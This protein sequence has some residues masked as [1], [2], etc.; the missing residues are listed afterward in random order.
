[1]PARPTQQTELSLSGGRGLG[2]P[3]PLT[4]LPAFTRSG[5]KEKGKFRGHPAAGSAQL[6]SG[7]VVVES[8]VLRGMFL[9]TLL[10]A[11]RSQLACLAF[12][13]LG[14]RRCGFRRE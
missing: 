3:A 6:Q 1:M 11:F 9:R 8:A 14:L 7:C 12:C 2:S 10:P 5:K 4:F 13:R